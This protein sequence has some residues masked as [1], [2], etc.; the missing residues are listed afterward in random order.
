MTLGQVGG[1]VGSRLVVRTRASIGASGRAGASL[2]ID[3]AFGL[4]AAA[5]PALRH[6]VTGVAR[7]DTWAFDAHKQ[8]NVP[9]DFGLAFCAHRTPTGPR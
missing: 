7:A 5:S 4:W 8:L 9:Y 2:H 3:W 6:L 1:P